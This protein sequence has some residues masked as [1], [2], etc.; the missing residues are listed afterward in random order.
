MQWGVYKECS[1]TIESEP[2]ARGGF[3]EAYKAVS[4]NDKK[5]YVV[6]K[7]LNA[8]VEGL[9][10]INE[11]IDKKETVRSLSKK[12]IQGKCTCLQKTWLNN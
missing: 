9:E 3:R 11:I 7:F 1:M 2:F 4:V 12:A 6:K 10:K 8:T 5:E